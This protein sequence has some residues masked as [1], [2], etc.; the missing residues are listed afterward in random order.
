MFCS[1]LPHDLA[2]AQNGPLALTSLQLRKSYLSFKEHLEYRL[3]PEI[4]TDVPP[5]LPHSAS[6]LRMLL[7]PYLFFNN[8]HLSTMKLLLPFL[9]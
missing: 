3:F 6:L 7:R 2:V 8:T 5:S 9:P 4:F 1:D